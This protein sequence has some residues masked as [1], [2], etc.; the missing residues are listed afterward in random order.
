MFCELCCGCNVTCAYSFGEYVTNI[1]FQIK[2]Q[3]ASENKMEEEK[4]KW[5]LKHT[6]EQEGLLNKN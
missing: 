6:C 2:F 4:K 1:Y 5:E 3:N